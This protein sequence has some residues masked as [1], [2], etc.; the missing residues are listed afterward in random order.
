MINITRKDIEQDLYAA[1]FSRPTFKNFIKAYFLHPQFYV[2]FLWRLG[3]AFFRKGSF[4]RI[5]AR[6]IQSRILN[7]CACQIGI[8]AKIGQRL[9]LPH[10][11]GIVI[12]DNAVVYDDVTLYQNVTIG[13]RGKIDEMPVLE[14]GVTVFSG[15]CILGP[16]KIG[17]H[18]IIGA[19]AVV[20]EDVPPYAVVAGIPARIIKQRSQSD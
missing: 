17:E 7:L 1:G 12:G 5:I 8:T 14:K 4:F 18:A 19:N 2:I 9:K 20:I 6:L 11:A 10:P 15:A 16:V 13:Q 3:A